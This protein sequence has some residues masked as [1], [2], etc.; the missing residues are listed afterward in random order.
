MLTKIKHL[1][2]LDHANNFHT[3]SCST[4][5]SLNISASV[6]MLSLNTIVPKTL[7]N[8]TTGLLGNYDGLSSN[9]FMMPNGTVLSQDISE[10][11]VFAYGKTCM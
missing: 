9:D 10:R 8:V 7:H 5:I 2:I 1:N 3:C 6:E 4:G 11:E